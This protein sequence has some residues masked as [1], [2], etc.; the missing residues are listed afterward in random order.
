M[1]SPFPGM[2]PYLEE[3]PFWSPL[4]SALITAMQGELKKRVPPRYTVWP[5]IYIWL[6]EPDAEQRMRS[7]E[8]DVSVS[9]KHRKK[10]ARGASATLA[11]PATALLPAIRRKGNRY[12]KI[13]EVRSERVVTVVELLSPANKTP[14][15]DYE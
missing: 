13:K 15:D 14:G 4:H 11:A 10:T 8:P 12:L 3:N 7:F 9:R 2:D 1:P 5:D 6:H